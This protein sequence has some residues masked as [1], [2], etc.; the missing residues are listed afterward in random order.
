MALFFRHTTKG[1]A[2][3]RPLRN[4]LAPGFLI[5]RFHAGPGSLNR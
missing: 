2:D 1:K 5:S 3:E 4:L